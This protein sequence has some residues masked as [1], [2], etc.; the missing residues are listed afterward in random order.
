M[1]APG[2][3]WS[4]ALRCPECEWHGGGIYSQNVVDRF[5]E[6]LD[7]GTQALLDDLDLLTR[8]NMEEQVERFVAALT[9]D[10]IF[11]EDF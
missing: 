1:P 8:A 9:D 10:L 7:D 2:R 6:V 5:D 4:I 3:R 11:P